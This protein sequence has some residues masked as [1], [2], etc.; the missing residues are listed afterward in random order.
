MLS[1]SNP[2]YLWFMAGMALPLAL[3]LLNLRQMRIV[4]FPSVRFL[5]VSRQP[6]DGR[7]RLRDVLLLLLRMVSIALISCLLAGPEWHDRGQGASGTTGKKSAVLV[8]DASASMGT[9]KRWDRALKK[10]DELLSSLGGWE[11]GFVVTGG[12]SPMCVSPTTEHWKIRSELSGLSPTHYLGEPL[13][14]LEQA[15][16]WLSSDGSERRLEIVSDFQATDWERRWGMVPAGI[17]VGLHDV[18]EA[19]ENGNCGISGVTCQRLGTQRLRV[20]TS[21]VNTGETVQEQELSVEVEG[22]KRV[23]RFSLES[24]GRSRI[25]M[26]FDGIESGKR[27]MARLS[28]D[29][30]APD[31]VRVFWADGAPPLKVLLLIDGSENSVSG[32]EAAFVSRALDS[33]VEGGYKRFTVTVQDAVMA[34][35]ED[36]AGC[37]GVFLLSSAGQLQR[38]TMNALSDLVEKGGIVFVTPSQTPGVDLRVL[39][40]MGI[41]FGQFRGISGQTGSERVDGVG[42]VEKDSV[43]WSLYSQVAESDLYLFPIRRSCRLGLRSGVRALM[44]S[45]SGQPLLS[46]M[47]KGQGHCYFMSFGFADWWGD[48]QVTNSFLPMLQELLLS[49]VADDYG[50]R[51]V[52]CGETLSDAS[53]LYLD[54]FEPSLYLDESGYIEVNMDIRESSFRFVAEL[55]MLELLYREGALK[56]KSKGDD[57]HGLELYFAVAFACVLCLELLLCLLFDRRETSNA[58]AGK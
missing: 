32:I 56:S 52:H 47:S 42:Q 38:D 55:D 31:N 9:G 48:F 2:V 21:L 29:S 34:T 13:S 33:Q 51:R 35:G 27:G 40:E 12:R 6:R 3:H 28:G 22:V 26:V 45:L 20:I 36:V 24:G 11:I 54:T 46:E 14:G 53:G 17:S 8:L 58:E 49:S 23:E 50:Y 37:H 10:V 30:Y 19:Q 15:V 1:F 18:K 39:R 4:V 57:E 7:R 25:V 44:S 16:S 5:R 41:D 43:L